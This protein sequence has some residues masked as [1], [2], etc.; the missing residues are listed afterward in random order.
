MAKLPDL[1]E[2]YGVSSRQTQ[3]QIIDALKRKRHISASEDRRDGHRVVIVECPDSRA[4]WVFRKITAIDSQA[5]LIHVEVPAS[6]FES[7]N[8]QE[9]KPRD[10][11]VQT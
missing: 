5:I 1:R 4:Q 9:L 7:I 2:V 8:V 3:H 10:A 6:S 11:P